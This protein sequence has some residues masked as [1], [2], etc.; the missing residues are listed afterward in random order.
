[1]AA[2]AAATG[3]GV[4]PGAVKVTSGGAEYPLPGTVTVTPLMPPVFGSTVAV[5]SA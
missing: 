3:E 4:L 2:V 1:M 5:P